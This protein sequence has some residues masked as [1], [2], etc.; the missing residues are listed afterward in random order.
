MRIFNLVLNRAHAVLA[1][2]ATLIPFALCRSVALVTAMLL[3]TGQLVSVP[4]AYAAETDPA[5][6]VQM[7]NINKAD[8]AALASALRGV[9][10]SRAEEIIRYREAYGPFKSVEELTD[11]KGIGKSTLE[12]NRSVITLE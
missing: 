8:A 12:K 10:S 1:I 3:S 11:V 4:A 5:P 9:G 7:V 6:A 2:G